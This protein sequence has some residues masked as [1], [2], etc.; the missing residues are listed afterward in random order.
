MAGDEDR[1]IL[2]R[3][4]RDPDSL[5][6][7]CPHSYVRGVY[8]SIINWISYVTDDKMFMNCELEMMWEEV[9]ISQYLSGGE[10]KSQNNLFLDQGLD[11][12]L[13]EHKAEI[14]ITNQG[15]GM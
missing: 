14:L 10:G 2:S 13:P 4:L 1:F 5:I 15:F 9:V 11:P 7:L 3:F 12:E 6:P 8:F